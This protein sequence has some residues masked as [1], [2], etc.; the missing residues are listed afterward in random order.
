VRPN[1]TRQPSAPT[2]GTSF[3]SGDPLTVLWEEVGGQLTGTAIGTSIADCQPY[4]E[5]EYEVV[6]ISLGPGTGTYMP[7]CCVPGRLTDATYFSQSYGNRCPGCRS[8]VFGSTGIW[9]SFLILH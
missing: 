1:S 4:Q 7:R 5:V 6:A 9:Q 3:L 8:K 2:V